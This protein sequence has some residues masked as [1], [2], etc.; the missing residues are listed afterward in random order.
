MAKQKAEESKIMQAK[1]AFIR[2]I[3]KIEDY[4]SQPEEDL[5]MT[6]EWIIGRD[7]VEDELEDTIAPPPYDCWKILKGQSRGKASMF[8]R[9][10]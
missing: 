6:P 3:L 8:S 7:T 5:D 2:G 4:D 9:E 10:V 1:K